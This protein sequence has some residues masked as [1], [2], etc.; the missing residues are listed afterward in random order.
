[1][2]AQRGIRDFEAL[3]ALANAEGLELDQDV[4]MPA[5]NQM[6]VWRR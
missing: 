6:L 2:D 4:A 1:M 5:N 3:A